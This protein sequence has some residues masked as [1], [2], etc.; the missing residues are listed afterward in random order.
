MGIANVIIHNV[1]WGRKV[2][3]LIPPYFQWTRRKVKKILDNIKP[4]LVIACNLV[5]GYIVDTIG[6]PMIL[7]YHEVWSLQ[8][9]Y[10]EPITLPRKITYMRRK[11]KYPRLEEEL[12]KNY[13]VITISYNAKKYFVDKYGVPDSMIFVVKNYPSML[14]VENLEFREVDCKNYRFSYIGKDLVY[15]DGQTYRDLRLTLKTLDKLWNENKNFTVYLVGVK[16]SNLPFVKALGRVRH[17]DI[18]N[19]VG[20]AHYGI[21]SYKPYPVQYLVNPNKAYMYAHSGALPITTNSLEE[22]VNELKPYV[23]PIDKDNYSES[24]LDTYKSLLE[25][26]CY[27][28]NKWRREMITHARSKLLWENQEN[29]I[30]HAIKKA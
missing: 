21:L 23:I 1:K 4:D 10:I 11:N 24:L 14:E 7:D 26:E 27:E 5:A 13:P 6:Y 28:I 18:Y 20:K 22:I 3:L 25:M 19:I 9:E 16:G 2:N 12:V 15:F 17:I 29:T 30:L 8:L